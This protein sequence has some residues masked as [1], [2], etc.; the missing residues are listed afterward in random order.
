MKVLGVLTGMAKGV[1]GLTLSALVLWQV[2]EHSTPDSSEVVVHVCEQGVDV[3][4]DDLGFRSNGIV[5][6]P[7]VCSVRAGKHVLRVYRAGK[8]IYEKEFT[9]RKG[10]DLILAAW[11]E[12]RYQEAREDAGGDLPGNSGPATAARF[13]G[14]RG[15]NPTASFTLPPP[16][17]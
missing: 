8:V 6:G 13:I 17:G 3:T 16:E 10:Q 5:D 9:V 12:N 4:V 11:D 7:V 14:P 1:A 2:A 15:W